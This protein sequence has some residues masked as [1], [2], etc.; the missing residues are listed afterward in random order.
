MI[1][2]YI[3]IMKA[4]IEF[5]NSKAKLLK[6]KIYRDIPQVK[7]LVNKIFPEKD[8]AELEG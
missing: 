6:E 8:A 5:I 7:E 2:S 1:L 4:K 3:P